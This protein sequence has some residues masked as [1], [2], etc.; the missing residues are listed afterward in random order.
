MCRAKQTPRGASSAKHSV[1]RPGCEEAAT[2][3]ARAAESRFEPTD[4]PNAELTSPAGGDTSRSGCSWQLCFQC[5]AKVRCLRLVRRR[6]SAVDTGSAV[7]ESCSARQTPQG[8]SS[9]KHGVSWHGCEEAAT[10]SAG[11]AESR[12]GPGE[13]PNTEPSSPDRAVQAVL[14]V[15][16]NSVSSVWPECVVFG[17][18]G[19][20]NL[21]WTLGGWRPCCVRSG[22]LRKEW[23]Q[24][25]TVSRGAAAKRPQRLRLEWLNPNLGHEIA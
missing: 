19:G 15:L 23:A 25:S 1:S 24:P 4:I 12:L 18:S 16:G 10:A 3:S 8:V 14:D 5:V 11:A 2:A 6:Q 9:A 7:A 20:D 17:L 13:P 22:R 21:R